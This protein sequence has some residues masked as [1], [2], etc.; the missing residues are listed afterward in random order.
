MASHGAQQQ[1]LLQMG[2]N[3]AFHEVV[4]RLVVAVAK[5]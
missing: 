3:V 2:L 4:A 1:R 5:F